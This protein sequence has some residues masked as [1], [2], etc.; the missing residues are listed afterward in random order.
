MCT[1]FLFVSFIILFIY[2]IDRYGTAA[3]VSKVASYDNYLFQS[4][5]FVIG[6]FFWYVLAVPDPPLVLYFF[7]VN[8]VIVCSE[9]SFS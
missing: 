7:S 2:N 5:L 3:N 9:V 8:N 4:L 1:I 6:G